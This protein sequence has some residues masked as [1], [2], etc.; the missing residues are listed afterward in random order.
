MEEAQKMTQGTIL[1]VDDMPANLELLASM[2]KDRGY[3]VRVAPSGALALRAMASHQPDLLLIDINMPEMNGYELCRQ[4]KAKEK[5]RSIPVIFI[6]ALNETLDKIEAF[7]VGGVD[8]VTK[9]F[10]FAEVEARVATQLQ[11]HRYQQ[12]LERLVA[13]KVQEVVEAQMAT[14]FA[15]VKLAESRDDDT[16]CH[17]ERVR[18]LCKLLAETLYEN[19]A[20]QPELSQNFI[21]NIYQAS[22]LHDIGKVGILDYILLKPAPLSAEEFEVMKTH[23]TLGATTLRAVHDQYP[24]NEFIKMGILV[25]AG[26]HEKWDG[27]G[28]PCGLA[29]EAI[30]L[31]SRIMALVDVYDALRSKRCYKEAFSAEKSRN[32]ILAG[33]GTHFDPKLVDT[34]LAIED[35][36][37]LHYQE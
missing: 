11:L 20:Y 32:I 5:W 28:Y 33:K 7:Q 25:A 21:N 37:L 22:V 6:S 36:I 23:T 27:S 4:I 34:F 2:L 31:A 19:G 12:G 24:Q 16:G 3:Q 8:Y 1:I 15:L 13:E 10:Q 29:G 26:H 17:L 35:Q 30:P 14:I 9:P 18:H